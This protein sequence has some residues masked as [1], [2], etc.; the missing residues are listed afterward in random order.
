MMK[1]D[2]VKGATMNKLF[3]CPRCNKTVAIDTAAKLYSY[4]FSCPDCPPTDPL[5]E[6]RLWEAV[7]SVL[8]ATDDE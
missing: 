8:V 3:A 5:K 7:G 6:R 1:Q 2:E 4:K